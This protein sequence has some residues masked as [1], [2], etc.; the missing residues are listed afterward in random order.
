MRAGPALFTAAR[1]AGRGNFSGLLLNVAGVDGG[2]F[3]EKR[4][5]SLVE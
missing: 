3:N 2:Y 1:L 5:G 4:I